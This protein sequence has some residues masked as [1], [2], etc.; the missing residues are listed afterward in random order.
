MLRGVEF[1]LELK[2]VPFF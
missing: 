1:I 2:K